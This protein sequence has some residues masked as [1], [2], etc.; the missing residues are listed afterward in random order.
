MKKLKKELNKILKVFLAF[1]LLFNNLMPLSVVFADELDNGE[2]KVV[3][4][5]EGDNLETDDEGE[6]EQ[7]PVIDTNE[8]EN[9]TGDNET[10]E[11]EGGETP[12]EDENSEVALTYEVYVDDA[13]FEDDYGSVELTKEVQKLD[14][15]AKLSG[16][17]TTD[18]YS[19]AF[20]DATYTV[21]SETT[22][23]KNDSDSDDTV[24]Y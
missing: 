3:D 1:G 2:N 12:S 15:I 5:G 4:I 22:E 23:E 20:E 24:K 21:E 18:S 8:G 11:P 9:P 13:K 16:A 6:E 14:I 7:N 19:F 10:T 17:E